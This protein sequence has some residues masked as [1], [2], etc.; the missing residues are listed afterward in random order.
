MPTSRVSCLYTLLLF[1]QPREKIFS[2]SSNL[3]SSSW[4][5]MVQHTIKRKKEK[6]TKDSRIKTTYKNCHAWFLSK[7]VKFK[8]KLTNSIDFNMQGCLSTD[9]NLHYCCSSTY[10]R[11]LT[12]RF[13]KWKV[14][15]KNQWSELYLLEKLGQMRDLNQWPSSHWRP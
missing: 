8:K 12:L 4:S 14:R 15:K 1:A 3:N 6:I 13:L 7:S 5:K 11:C 9:T 10:D 2:N